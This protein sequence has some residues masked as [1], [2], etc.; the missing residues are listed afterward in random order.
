MWLATDRKRKAGSTVL[1]DTE[2]HTLAVLELG[3]ST[4]NIWGHAVS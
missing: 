3:K 2:K 4:L 1:P